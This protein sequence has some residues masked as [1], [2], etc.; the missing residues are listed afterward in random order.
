MMENSLDLFN[1]H[2]GPPCSAE[3]LP[4]YKINNMLQTLARGNT[5]DSGCASG[6]ANTVSANVK[7]RGISILR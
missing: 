3:L 5:L 7:K 1:F 4:S 2:N 6:Q